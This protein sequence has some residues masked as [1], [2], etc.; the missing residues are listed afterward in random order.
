MAAISFTN[1]TRNIFLPAAIN[2]SFTGGDVW[3]PKNIERNLGADENGLPQVLLQMSLDLQGIKEI[4]PCSFEM[5]SCSTCYCC[6]ALITTRERVFFLDWIWL[7]FP[8]LP[9]SRT[10]FRL[11][12]SHCC[13]PNTPSTLLPRGLCTDSAPCLEYFSQIVTWLTPFPPHVKVFVPMR[14]SLSTP[15][16]KM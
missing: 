3:S 1:A 14:C 13:S 2:H 9:P 4:F 6:P 7:H 8:M 15:L 5:S 10:Q 12:S 16:L 11:C